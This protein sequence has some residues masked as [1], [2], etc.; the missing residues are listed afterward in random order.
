MR[1]NA[2][3]ADSGADPATET[4]SAHDFGLLDLLVDLRPG[5]LAGDHVPDL[6]AAGEVQDILVGFAAVGTWLLEDDVQLA[7]DHPVIGD[8]LGLSAGQAGHQASLL[9]RRA[10]RSSGRNSL[11]TLK[12]L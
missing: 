12:P 1:R 7:D 6:V 8:V 11:I 2:V 5:R 10:F 3:P 9:N 4:V